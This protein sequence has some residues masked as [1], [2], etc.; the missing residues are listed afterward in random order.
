MPLATK[1][2]KKRD[3]AAADERYRKAILKHCA[4][5]RAR[6]EPD[7][8]DKGQA[9]LE[10]ERLYNTVRDDYL[11]DENYNENL[12]AWVFRVDPGDHNTLDEMCDAVSK[13]ITERQE[14]LK[15][16]DFEVDTVMVGKGKLFIVQVDP[17]Q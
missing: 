3:E 4:N 5:K 2:E 15:D 6:R 1:S 7:R 8:D 17:V 14:R 10:R 12:D 16:Y 13:A 9:L 11:D